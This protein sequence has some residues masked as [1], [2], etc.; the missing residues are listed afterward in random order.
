VTKQDPLLLPLL[1]CMMHNK[2]ARLG[3]AAVCRWRCAGAGLA[4]RRSVQE[5]RQAAAVAA[6]C[7]V[8][9]P[10]QPPSLRTTSHY[11]RRR[12]MHA[13]WRG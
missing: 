10:A 4:P 3:P 2:G 13:S 9:L 7:Q 1:L 12:C 6:R 5:R 8:P 11:I